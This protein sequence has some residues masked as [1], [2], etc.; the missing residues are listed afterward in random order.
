MEERKP[1][2]PRQ[3]RRAKW[4]DYRSRAIY[5]ITITKAAGI[6]KFGEVVQVSPFAS[7]ET[8][9]TPLGKAIV[10]EL[11][12]MTAKYP[13][14]EIFEY[15]IM[16][17]HI[18][19]ILYVKSPTGYHLGKAIGDFKGACSRRYLNI[20]AN[21]ES[22]ITPVF[23]RGF[24]D[25]ILRA[26]GQLSIMKN[27]VRDNPRRLHIKRTKP[28]LFSSKQTIKINGEEFDA[29]GNIF[30][31]RNPEIE[32]VKVS[33]R[34]S[35]EELRLLNRRW[36]RTIE[37]GGVLVSPFISPKEKIYRDLAIDNGANVIILLENGFGERFKPSGQYFDLCAEGRLLLIAPKEHTNR[38]E[39]LTRGQALRM[40]DL[41]ASL[42]SGDFLA[43]L[44]RR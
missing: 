13:E 39:A 18:H 44:S 33:S 21:E 22:E 12:A 2:I 20:C 42:V 16:P 3:N 32:A 14:L 43:S 17:D 28:D 1:I 5:M 8:E 29:F 9:L 36:I 38:R 30:L 15:V 27:Y 10:V 40:N 4:H 24:H 41:A 23:S 34:F 25:R 35:E 37:E 6:P 31:L 19:F 26:K 11:K 7:V